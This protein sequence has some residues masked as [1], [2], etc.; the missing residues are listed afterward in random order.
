MNEEQK[1]RKPQQGPIGPLEN[2]LTNYFSVPIG[3]LSKYKFYIEKK[4][5]HFLDLDTKDQRKMRFRFESA[6][7]H[8]RAIDALSKIF[9]ISKHKDLFTFDFSKS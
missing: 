9:E 6:F 2:E 4:E 8:Q 7:S 5:H 1:G 3:Y